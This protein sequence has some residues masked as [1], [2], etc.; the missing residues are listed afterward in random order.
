M[1]MNP[2]MTAIVL[3]AGLGTRLRPYTNDRPK[4]LFTINQRPLLAL[5]IEQ[6][7]ASGFKRILVN[8]HH[9]HRQIEAFIDQ[10]AFSVPVVLRHEPDILG[11]GG[12][13]RNLAD[14][15]APGPLLVINADIVTSIDPGEVYRFHCRHDHAVTMVL[16]HRAEFNTVSVHNGFVTGFASPET[17]P[18][19]AFTGI[20][21]MDGRILDFLPDS[22]PAHII[23]AYSAMIAAGEKICA[24]QVRDHYWQDI[25]TPS[26]YRDAAYTVMAPLAFREAFGREPAEPVQRHRLHGD[27]S[28][29]Q[30][31]RLSAGDR[32]LIMADH[33]LRRGTQRQEVDA[34]IDIGRHLQSL[35]LAVPRI[36]LYDRCAGLVFLED[37]GDR[38]LQH[39]MAR[40]DARQAGALYRRVIDLWLAMAIEGMHTFDPNWTYQTPRFDGQVVLENECRYFVDAF[41]RGHLGL[42]VP[43]EALAEEFQQLADHI[44]QIATTG[45]MH[46]DLQSR[47]IMVGEKDIRFIDFQ[48]GR[49]GPL[50]YDLASLLIDPY[51]ALGP[52]LQDDL[53][54]YCAAAL[55]RYKIDSSGFRKG[56]A[57]CAL[58]RNLQILGAFAFLGNTKGKTQFLDHVPVAVNQL[59]R[60]LAGFEEEDWPR[61]KQLAGTLPERCSPEISGGMEGRR[62]R[63][64]L[65][66]DEGGTE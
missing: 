40:A 3:A 18:G 45:F 38:H 25:G 36:H 33:H 19:L 4:A 47:N 26:R 52:N 56:Y 55:R 11:T 1:A 20:H 2:N 13:I 53:V 7:I 65:T 60:T 43:F 39:V 6:L 16:H 48:G 32:T 28:D 57:Y 61:L 44:S 37:L 9:L 22:G 42:D 64:P 54:G 59:N 50:Q 8:T 14:Q 15:W 27:G 41:V 63:P 58:S 21:V 17:E 35:N 34:Y 29:R 31:Y 62:H 24:Y 10:S 46:R 49:V 51:V 30:W 12:G 23:D 5:V 66:P